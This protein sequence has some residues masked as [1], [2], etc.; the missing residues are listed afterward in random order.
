MSECFVCAK[1]IPSS[2]VQQPLKIDG[3]I[4]AACFNCGT[5]WLSTEIEVFKITF[6]NSYYTLNLMDIHS[7][8]P[9]S[10][11]EVE[12]VVMEQGK[13]YAMPEFRGF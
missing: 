10:V 9:G 1:E 4:H 3:R 7:M 13:F 5:S 8:E 2:A 11:Y 6:G 12:K